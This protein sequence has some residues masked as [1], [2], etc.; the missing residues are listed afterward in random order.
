MR[1]DEFDA[2]QFLHPEINAAEEARQQAQQ[3][4]QAVIENVQRKCAHPT[5][6]EYDG[7]YLANGWLHVR[8]CLVCGLSVD[9]QG[10]GFWRNDP[11]Y[12]EGLIRLPLRCEAL[13][14]VWRLRRGP[15]RNRKDAK[16]FLAN[17]PEQEEVA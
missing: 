1:Q 13:D 17:E 7:A 8:V 12:V 4:E 9:A 11:L 2:G 3:H 14:E 10:C 5:I 15:T 16:K 6:A